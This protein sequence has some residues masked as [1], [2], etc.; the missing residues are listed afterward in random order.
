SDALEVAG[1][2]VDEPASS[3]PILG[4]QEVPQ[5]R[6]E[7][8]PDGPGDGPPRIDRLSRTAFCLTH[9]NP[10]S[11]VRLPLDSNDVDGPAEPRSRSRLRSSTEVGAS[12]NRSSSSRIRRM[13]FSSDD[14][15]SRPKCARRMPGSVEGSSNWPHTDPDAHW[16]LAETGDEQGRATPGGGPSLGRAGW[17]SRR[18]PGLVRSWFRVDSDA[19]RALD[20]LVPEFGVVCDFVPVDEPVAA[21][22]DGAR[23]QQ[24]AL[25]AHA[26]LPRFVRATALPE[27]AAVGRAEVARIDAPLCGAGVRVLPHA[28][29]RDHDVELV[30][31]DVASRVRDLHDH[32]LASDRSRAGIV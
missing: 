22:A 25:V 30:A 24:R 26:L 10:P 20:G 13:A 6:A 5:G 29:T 28:A 9:V 8:D 23:G 16:P 31:L 2:V 4:I 27:E 18:P 7:P 14:R 1:L 19:R 11:L 21:V 17:L 12:P 32:V 15:S 3:A